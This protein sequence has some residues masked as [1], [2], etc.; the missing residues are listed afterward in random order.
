VGDDDQWAALARVIGR[1]ELASA[2]RF[3]DVAGRQAHHDELDAMIGGWTAEQD[4]VEAFHLLQT[5]GVAA[6]PQFDDDLL[7]DDPNVAARQWLRPLTSTDTGTHLHI[8]HPFRGV[9]QVWERGSPALGE[10]NEYVYK[11]VIGIDDDEYQRLQDDKIVVSDYL[12][13]EGNPV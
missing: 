3:A 6:A 10:D 2:S 12:D 9:P 4:V 7:V 8:G 5:A 1:P 13:A 11:K